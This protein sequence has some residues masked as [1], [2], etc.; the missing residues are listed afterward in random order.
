MWNTS[1]CNF[2]ATAQ[3]KESPIFAQSGHPAVDR[4]LYVH[5]YIKKWNATWAQAAFVQWSA[6][7]LSARKI[8][9]SNLRQVVVRCREFVHW[10]AVDL[11]TFFANW[12]FL[13]FLLFFSL[14]FTFF[15]MFHYFPLF[16]YFLLFSL[17]FAKKT[18]RL[19]WSGTNKYF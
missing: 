6:A 11:F 17:F 19:S 7:V 10:N 13:L 4:L 18:K 15:T 9:G 8:V 14:F 2:Q 1:V 5:M 16:N 12:N 3:R